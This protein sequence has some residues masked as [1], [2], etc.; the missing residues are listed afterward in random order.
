MTILVTGATGNIGRHVVAGLR[1]RGADL[2]TLSR[3]PGGPETTTGDLTDPSTLH[4]A[5]SEVDTVFLLW[6][7]LSAD[8][9][10]DV[11]KVIAEHA[12]RVVYVSALSVRDAASPEENGVWGQVED[13]IRRSGMEWTFLRAG[14]F[15]TN[16]LEWAPAIRAGKPARM[17]YPQASRSLIHERDIADVAVLA[18]TEDG[19]AGKAY[20]LTGPEAITQAEQVRVIGA[21]AG[22]PATVEELTR[23]EARADMAGWGDYADA[24]LDYWQSIVAEPEP[25]LPTVEELTG[26]PARTFTQWARDHADDFRP[27]PASEVAE[28]Y[29]AAFRAGRMDRTTRWIAPDVVRVAPLETDGEH[30]ERRGHTEVMANARQLI[31]DLEFH[32]VT[33]EGPFLQGDRFAVRFSFDVT[34]RRTG[35]R[36]TSAKMSLYT[37]ADGVITR[38]EVFYFDPPSI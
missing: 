31:Q 35:Q 1:E 26:H 22:R 13:A 27:L 16:T 25:V 36:G 5:L 32:S 20:A 29:V 14:G 12:R 34:D 11:V 24:A 30:V 28:R 18:L 21:A 33:V 7:F 10:T 15:A 17:P 23:E 37:V 2:R 4:A 8:G 9:V 6:P 19:H 3:F 38:E